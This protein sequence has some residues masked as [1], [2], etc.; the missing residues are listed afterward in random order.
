MSTQSLTAVSPVPWFLTVQLTGTAWP[1][2]PAPGA[3]AAETIR[4]AGFDD[5][6]VVFVAAAALFD[7]STSN[8]WSWLSVT[9]NTWY[10]PV[11]PA[12]SVN[13]ADETYDAVEPGEPAA[14]RAPWCP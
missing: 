1:A 9:T 12:A 8:T 6:T 5:T 10:V 3:E 4:S 7:L 13:V 2:W 14:S 11:N